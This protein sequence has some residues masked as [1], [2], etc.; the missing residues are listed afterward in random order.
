MVQVPKDGVAPEAV[1]KIDQ[2]YTGDVRKDLR[3]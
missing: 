3:L 1:E 2:A